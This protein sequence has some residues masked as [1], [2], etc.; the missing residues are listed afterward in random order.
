VRSRLALLTGAVGGFALF[1]LLGRARRGAGYELSPPAPAPDPRAEELR[2]KLAESRAVA[3]E[4]DE[5]EGAET[6]VDEAEPLSDPGARRKQVHE[7]ARAAA[8]R[9][10]G[11]GEGP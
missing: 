4:R 10:R 2:R 8:E 11:G 1:R 3:D 9:M 7:Q 5:F 6:P